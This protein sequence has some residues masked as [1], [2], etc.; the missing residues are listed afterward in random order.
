MQPDEAVLVE[1]LARLGVEDPHATARSEVVEDIPQ[2]AYARLER[3]V[4]TNLMRR[5][6]GMDVWWSNLQRERARRPES[7]AAEVAEVV[8]KCLAA[9]ITLDE[10][11]VV[12][13]DVA[14][15]TAQGFAYL[16]GDPHDDELGDPSDLPSWALCEVSSDDDGAKLTGRTLSMLHEFLG[17]QE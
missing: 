4:R 9:G 15:D 10:L 7:R 14:S 5:R 16:L 2:L 13:D 6:Q 3:L 8:R 17:P 1:R 12:V 11:G